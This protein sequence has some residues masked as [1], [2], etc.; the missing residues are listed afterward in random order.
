MAACGQQTAPT[1]SAI[2][3]TEPVSPTIQ[4]TSAVTESASPTPTP[5]A[6][7]SSTP[8]ATPSSITTPTARPAGLRGMLLTADELK[9]SWTADRTSREGETGTGSCQ[10][11]S[12]STIGALSSLRRTFLSGDDSAVQVVAKF[13]D[14]KSAWRSFE[15]LKSWRERCGER[16]P[17]GSTVSSLMTVNAAPAVGHRYVVTQPTDTATQYE[18]VG[19]VR[20]GEYISLIAFFHIG[21]AQSFPAGQDPAT[22]AV[23]AIAPL[24]G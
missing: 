14:P 8:S 11:T 2:D 23:K 7:G 20:R 19:L 22:L 12:M 18:R 13:A 16:L 21:S 6:S 10:V 9:G 5:T 15:V 3:P 1:S 4:T 24:L 17:E